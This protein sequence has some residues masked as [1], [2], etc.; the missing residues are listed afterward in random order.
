MSEFTMT[1]AKPLELK[2]SATKATPAITFQVSNAETSFIT[3]DSKPKEPE[4]V[5][6][7]EEVLYVDGM[8][9]DDIPED[10]DLPDVADML[11]K[12]E[13]VKM[14]LIRTISETIGSIQDELA[15][16]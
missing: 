9:Y 1:L 2:K 3:F 16:Y 13:L 11:D 5:E 6:E 8:L 12:L 7:D 10:D 15:N 14:S 4:P